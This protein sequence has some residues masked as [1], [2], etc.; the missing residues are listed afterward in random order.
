M[1]VKLIELLL[2]EAEEDEDELEK[3]LKRSF[4][5]FMAMLVL[6]RMLKRLGEPGCAEA[7]GTGGVK[8]CPI[9]E[10]MAA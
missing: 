3:K 5:S 6:D 1:T 10:P 9:L 8:D 2:V 7:E 4:S